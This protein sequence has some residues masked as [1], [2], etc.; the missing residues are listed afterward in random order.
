[1][2]PRRSAPIGSESAAVKAPSC[3]S[4]LKYGEKKFR[5]ADFPTGRNVRSG[6]SREGASHLEVGSLEGGG[7]LHNLMNAAREMVGAIS[8]RRDTLAVIERHSDARAG[9]TRDIARPTEESPRFG[10]LSGERWKRRQDQL[11]SPIRYS[12]QSQ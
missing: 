5:S 12:E 10:V 8:D 4:D 11:R 1:M 6:G 2:A 3:S 9:T 7:R